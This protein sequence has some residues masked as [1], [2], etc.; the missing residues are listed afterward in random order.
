MERRA[1]E[2]LLAGD[3]EPFPTLRE[4]WAR[5]WVVKRSHTNWGLIVAI[6][7]PSGV[8]RA[9]PPR[10]DLSDVRLEFEH[11]VGDGYAACF[12]DGGVLVELEVTNWAGPW[13]RRYQIRSVGYMRTVLPEND[14]GDAE[15]I[16]LAQRDW[17]DVH[18]TLKEAE[19]WDS[20]AV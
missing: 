4:Q 17:N 14:D 11:D 5:A 16:P 15:F 8:R 1:M 13:Q 7:V 9:Q 3:E 20:G 6:G 12:V 18:A 19:S 10:F 2:A